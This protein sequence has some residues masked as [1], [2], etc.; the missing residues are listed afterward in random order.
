LE[1][2]TLMCSGHHGLEKYMWHMGTSHL[3]ITMLYVLIEI[4]HRKRGVEVDKAWRSIGEVFSYYPQVFEESTGAVYKALGKWT[5]EVWD[6]CVAASGANGLREPSTPDYIN[7]IRRC[8]RPTT[9]SPPKAKV[10][11]AGTHDPSASDQV[12]SEAYEG[13]VHALEPFE[14]YGFPDLLSFEMDPN[15]WTQW[16]QLVAEQ[17]GFAQV[18][19]M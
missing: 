4:R 6:D 10:V 7:A 16:E 8:R 15:E 5:L 2:V 18:D 9:Q 19:N 14:P 3:W 13:H 1:Y 17:G 11:A 12:P